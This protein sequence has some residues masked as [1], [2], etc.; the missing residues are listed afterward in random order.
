MVIFE[1]LAGVILGIIGHQSD[2]VIKLWEKRGTARAWTNLTRYYIGITMGM[3]LY[4]IFR[5]GTYYGQEAKDD[6]RAYL[7]TFYTLGIGV[8]VGY[9]YDDYIKK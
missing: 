9:L 5:R 8:L 4:P 2:R 3:I 7:V 1:I 6:I